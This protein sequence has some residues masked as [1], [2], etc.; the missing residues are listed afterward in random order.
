LEQNQQQQLQQQPAAAAALLAG[1]LPAIYNPAA[2]PFQAP[3][4]NFFPLA[5]DTAALMY[6]NLAYLTPGALPFRCIHLV[7]FS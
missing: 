4:P 6:Q 1:N 2:F 5:R 3:P 7:L